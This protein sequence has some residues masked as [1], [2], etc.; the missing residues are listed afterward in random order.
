MKTPGSQAAAA[1]TA[2]RLRLQ[3]GNCCWDARAVHKSKTA[4]EFKA[5][6]AV[7]VMTGGVGGKRGGGEGRPFALSLDIQVF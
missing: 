1:D 6:D 5:P 7:C 2:P 4:Q 3:T